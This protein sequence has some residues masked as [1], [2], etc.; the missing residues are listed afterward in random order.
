M[1]FILVRLGGIVGEII[2][3]IVS[4]LTASLPV[5]GILLWYG[6]KYKKKNT[7]VEN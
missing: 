7:S 6:R 2:A 3:F 1:T 4:L 5:T